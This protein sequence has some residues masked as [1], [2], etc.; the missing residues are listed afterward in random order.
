MYPQVTP[1]LELRETISS[2]FD[3]AKVLGFK[4]R[5]K[6]LGKSVI[7]MKDIA[8]GDNV[9]KIPMEQAGQ[10]E[11]EEAE[12]AVLFGSSVKMMKPEDFG[13]EYRKVRVVKDSNA[14][15]IAEIPMDSDSFRTFDEDRV[16]IS[17]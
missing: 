5:N 9:V 11:N 7:V 14:Q 2:P 10:I 15:K 17:N 13:Q 6:R 8:V 12:L 1:L 3:S 16:D 4:G